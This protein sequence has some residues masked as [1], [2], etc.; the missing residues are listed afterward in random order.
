MKGLIAAVALAMTT[1]PVL[2]QEA[3]TARGTVAA[4]TDDSLTVNVRDHAMTFMIDRATQLTGL[5]SERRTAA[6]QKSGLAPKPSD[7]FKVGQPVEVS[8]HDMVGTL[9]AAAVRAAAPAAAPVRRTTGI[10]K[11]LTGSSLTVTSNGKDMTFVIDTATHITAAG[12]STTSAAVGGK[13]MITDAVKVGDRVT[14]NYRESGGA[15]T[16]SE[17]RVAKM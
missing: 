15:R 2:A 8:Y 16:A 4:M 17:V 12:A 11:S 7:V 14:V 10:V 9:H 5:S 3:K 6:N 13:L 1:L